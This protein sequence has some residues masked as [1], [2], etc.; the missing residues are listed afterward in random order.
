[1]C[2]CVCRYIYSAWK[3][4]YMHVYICMEVRGQPQ[5]TFLGTHMPLFNILSLTGTSA[6][7]VGYIATEPQGCSGLYFSSAGVSNTRHQ[8]WFLHMCQESKL[9]SLACSYTPFSGWKGTPSSSKGFF[10]F[11]WRYTHKEKCYRLKMIVQVL[12]YEDSCWYFG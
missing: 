11:W 1:V 7:T 6:C 5:V 2:V 9:A 3:Y 4:T 10:F 12:N 8:A